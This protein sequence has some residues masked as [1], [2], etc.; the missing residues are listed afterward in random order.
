MPRPPRRGQPC[1]NLIYRARLDERSHVGARFIAPTS[2]SVAMSSPP[3]VNILPRPL[4][5]S[6]KLTCSLH[7]PDK[8]V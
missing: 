6:N 5:L 1:R 2:T 3:A 7:Q 8:F 4:N